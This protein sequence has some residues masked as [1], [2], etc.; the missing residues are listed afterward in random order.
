M[1]LVRLLGPID[2]V[3]DDG[4]VC[5]PGTPLR[6]TL[7]ALLALQA[8]RVVDGERLLD[9][10]WN[11][12]PPASGVRSLRIHVSKLREELPA[13]L[14]V[15]VPGGYRIDAEVD[16]T[17]F[18]SAAGDVES[19]LGLWRGVPFI[20]TSPCTVLE[21]E[22][23]RLDE[24]R[25]SSIERLHRGHV[26]AGDYGR[27]IAELVGLC[28]DHPTRESL[29][30]VLIEAHYRSGNQGEALAVVQR[31]RLNL[32]EQLGVDPSPEIQAL[33]QRI[34]EH[35][36]TLTPTAQPHPSGTVTFMFTDI[37]DSSR[38]WDRHPIQM[39]KALEVHDRIL[40]TV[41]SSFGGFVFSTAGDSFAAAF[42][43]AETGAQAA[44][45][46][47]AAV[48]EW[49]WDSDTPIRVRIGLH[50]GEAHERGGDYFGPAV[51]RAAR[52]EA[53]GHGGQT[54]VS[55]VTARLLAGSTTTVWHL[56]DLGEHHLK[57]LTEPEQIYQ[58][59]PGS[60]P[61]EFGPLRVAHTATTNLAGDPVDL[62]GR[63]TDI[64]EVVGLVGAHRVVTVTGIGG[65]GKTSL[66]QAVAHRSLDERDEVWFVV[67]TP[68]SDSND[69]ASTVAKTVGI[70]GPT[71]DIAEITAALGRRDDVLVVLDNCEHVVDGAADLVEAFAAAANVSVLAT[72][73]LEL[74]TAGEQIVRL[75]PLSVAEPAAE[76]FIREAQ[77]RSPAFA[78]SENDRVV[79]EQICSRVDGLP[80]AIELAAAKTA[81]MDVAT[82]RDRLNELLSVA[83]RRQRGDIRHRTMTAAIDWSINLLDPDVAAGLG[84][85]TVFSGTFDLQAAEA[86]IPTVIQT[87]PVEIIEELVAHSLVEPVRTDI[88]TRYR[89]LEP[90]RQ[91]ATETLLEDPAPVRDA[92]LEHYLERLE[93]AHETLGTTSC[94]PIMNLMSH[95]LDN[96]RAV[97]D[98]ALES[99]RIDD[100]LRLYRPLQLSYWHS[101][102]EPQGW[103][104]ETMRVPRIER[105]PGWGIAWASAIQD[106][107]NRADL[108][109]VQW[110]YGR[111]EDISPDDPGARMATGMRAVMA[112]FLDGDWDSVAALSATTDAVNSEDTYIRF[113]W[114]MVGC[115]LPVLRANTGGLEVPEEI[116]D[117]TISAI[118]EGIAWTI[119]IGA[120]NLEAAL[121]QMMA[122]QLTRVGRLDQALEAARRGEHMSAKLNMTMYED[123]CSFHQVVLS[124]LGVDI[125]EPP[126]PRLVRMLE[127]SSNGSNGTVLQYALK[128]AARFLAADGQ[129]HLAALCALQPV[130]SYRDLLP[131]LALDDITPDTWAA[132]AAENERLTVFDI[133]KRATESLR[134]LVS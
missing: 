80:L 70:S 50:S 43:T 101:E 19:V 62:V 100:D 45:N 124:M 35:D 24:V 84:A 94:D 67:L 65:V 21:H 115:T 126:V 77:R 92:H 121:V 15:T 127:S 114:Y 8:G 44:L 131:R 108:A 54:L 116:A 20:D 123:M 85:C 102:H 53:A 11:G 2:V 132:A 29:W 56:D 27:V 125:G 79:I 99:D 63:D 12:E 134:E 112:A 28:L 75:G 74:E 55:A 37:K 23:R 25:C 97:H 6:R 31:L 76:L 40:S 82:I 129:H 89:L 30:G 39:R 93:A 71:G 48:G 78:A 38:L 103:A 59:D 107:S 7:L 104:A 68:L 32:V 86:V 4:G 16:V 13:G 61:P 110:L 73:R 51:N 26:E 52:I 22:R 41:I 105:H 36:P 109:D 66:A 91:R 130:S 60:T 88:G 58:L 57:G 3:G 117:A 72:S 5:A 33:E 106:A 46:V 98:W 1:A 18:G 87:A 111:F 119:S 42:Q 128:P 47:Q 95:D 17:E 120:R 69:V 10:A 34:L 133:A 14:I 96:F 81:V 118:D 9:E 49:V 83:G 64:D 90:V 113:G 122:N